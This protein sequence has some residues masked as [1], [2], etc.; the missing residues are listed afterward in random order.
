MAARK[1]IGC[2]HIGAVF[3]YM[4]FTG[5]FLFSMQR[6][7]PGK[8]TTKQAVGQVSETNCLLRRDYKGLA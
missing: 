8:S 3:K 7:A 5:I 4:V 2:V 1:N 6:S